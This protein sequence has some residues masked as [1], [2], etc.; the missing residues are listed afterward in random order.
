MTPSDWAKVAEVGTHLFGF[1]FISVIVIAL[2]PTWR[3]Q[4]GAPI[5]VLTMAVFVFTFYA[6]A[7]SHARGEP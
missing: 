4:F 2:V 6:A 1:L 5:F 3:Q 7:R